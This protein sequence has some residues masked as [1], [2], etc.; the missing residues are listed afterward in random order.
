MKSTSGYYFNLGSE[1][2]SWCSEKQEIV[3]QSTTK[4]EFIVATTTTIIN[5]VL[6]LK[7]NSM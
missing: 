1:V 6:W 7:K 5:Q 4:A 3:A 2:F